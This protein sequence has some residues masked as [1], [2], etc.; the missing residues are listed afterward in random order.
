[1][2]RVR[3][4]VETLSVLVELLCVQP[5]LLIVK[6]AVT[7]RVGVSSASLDSRFHL[8]MVHVLLAVA[9]HSVLMAPS[10]CHVQ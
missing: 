10:V 4:A 8:M 6:R 2:A 9:R 5:V 7:V 3:N 1:M